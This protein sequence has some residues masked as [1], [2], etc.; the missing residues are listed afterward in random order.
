M[1]KQLNQVQVNLAF[2]A[3]TTQ[4][5]RQ[6]QDLQKSLTNLTNNSFGNKELGL[7]KEIENAT[8]AAAQLKVQLQSATNPQ[9]GKLDL[10]LFDDAMR[11]SGMSLEKYRDQLVQLGPEGQKAFLG[12]AQSITNAELPL[13]RSSQVLDQF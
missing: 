8:A 5:K 10:G 7:T 4:A 2:T 12:L 1:P 11:K 13:R 6:L 9:T 3:D